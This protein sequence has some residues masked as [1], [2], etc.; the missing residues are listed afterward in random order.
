MTKTGMPCRAWNIGESLN[1]FRE[2]AGSRVRCV[3]RS[4]VNHTHGVAR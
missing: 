1:G 3:F 4:E 2:P